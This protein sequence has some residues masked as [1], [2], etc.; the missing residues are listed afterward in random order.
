M[1]TGRAQHTAV[2]LP[3]G[4]VLIAGGNVGGAIGGIPTALAELYSSS[5]P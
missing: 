2:L 5:I 4:Q 3:Q 1:L